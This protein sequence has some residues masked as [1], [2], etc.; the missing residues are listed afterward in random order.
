MSGTV[1]LYP[2]LYVPTTSKRHAPA[3]RPGPYIFLG[4]STN[5]AFPRCKI[6]NQ[7]TKRN[8][9]TGEDVVMPPILCNCTKCFKA[10]LWYFG[11]SSLMA[12]QEPS[13]ASFPPARPVLMYFICWQMQKQVCSRPGN[14]SWRQSCGLLVLCVT[15][16]PFILDWLNQHAHQPVLAG[17]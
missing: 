6:P 16:V 12:D 1:E 8:S 5:G 7:E 13:L 3:H 2:S 9:T 15:P 17:S 11:M 10:S 4:K 14:G